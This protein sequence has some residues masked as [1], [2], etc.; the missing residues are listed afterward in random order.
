MEGRKDSPAS[1]LI[2]LVFLKVFGRVLGSVLGSGDPPQIEPKH[3]DKRENDGD[4]G[5]GKTPISVITAAT[6]DDK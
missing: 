3:A 6:E 2:L 1:T 5:H 4:L